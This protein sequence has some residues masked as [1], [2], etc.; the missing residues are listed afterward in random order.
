MK[1]LLKNLSERLF[2]HQYYAVIIG[3]AGSNRYD[4]A[5][6][7]HPDRASA[8]AH[9]LRIMQTRSFVYITTVKFRS[10]RSL[11]PCPSLQG[12]ARPVTFSKAEGN[13]RSSIHPYKSV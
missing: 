10:K 7:I 9:H 13:R 4:I 6:Q 11:A 5:S 8:E 12:D 2:G 1:T 3:E